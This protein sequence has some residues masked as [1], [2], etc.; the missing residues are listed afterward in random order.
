MGLLH[1]AYDRRLMALDM[2]LDEIGWQIVVDR[3]H[4]DLDQPLRRPIS[5]MSDADDQNHAS[6]FA[7]IS[8]KGRE[9]PGLRRSGAPR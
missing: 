4:P 1:A 2:D 7:T 8:S 3:R 5:G 9:V 6:G